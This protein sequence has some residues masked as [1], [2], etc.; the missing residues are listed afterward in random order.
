MLNL[1]SYKELPTNPIKLDDNTELNYLQKMLSK[2]DKEMTAQIL[3]NL[4]PTRKIRKIDMDIGNQLDSTVKKEDLNDYSIKKISSS[5][6]PIAE[7]RESDE[8]KDE[9]Q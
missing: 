7:K 4:K 6:L 2:N 9:E 5:Q 1:S 3:E 8:M